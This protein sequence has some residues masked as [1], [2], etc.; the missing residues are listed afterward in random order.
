MN[1]KARHPRLS[2]RLNQVLQP[3][4]NLLGTRKSDPDVRLDEGY[5]II[6][7]NP[8]L[9]SL[10]HLSTLYNGRDV[11]P[12]STA[13]SPSDR[14]SVWSAVFNTSRRSRERLSVLVS[15]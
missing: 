12:V 3:V 8:R 4:Q 6:L 9:P 11:S 1:Q 10:H 7:A 14:L 5:A 15:A 2:R 13:R